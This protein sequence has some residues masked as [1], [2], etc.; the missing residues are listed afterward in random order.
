MPDRLMN[1]RKAF[2]IPI[3]GWSDSDVS[4]ISAD[5]ENGWVA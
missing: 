3:V 4:V 2:S 5:M 1:W